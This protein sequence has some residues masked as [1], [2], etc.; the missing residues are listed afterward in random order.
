M[1]DAAPSSKRQFGTVAHSVQRCD[2]EALITVIITVLNQVT[3]HVNA[4]WPI[5]Q[6]ERSLG[7]R[8]AE[9]KKT[10]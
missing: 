7:G 6:N 2:R 1:V 4:N 10:V 3:E 9:F 8:S 5:M